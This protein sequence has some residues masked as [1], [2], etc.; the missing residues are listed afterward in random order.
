MSVL[1]WENIRKPSPEFLKLF[2]KTGYASESTLE[3][4]GI[5]KPLTPVLW[6]HPKIQTQRPKKRFMVDKYISKNPAEQS[7]CPSAEQTP[8]RCC[9][10]AAMLRTTSRG[11]GGKWKLLTQDGGNQ[12]VVQGSCSGRAWFPMGY[13][14]ALYVPHLNS[15]RI[16]SSPLPLCPCKILMFPQLL[17]NLSPHHSI[18]SLPTVFTR[19]CY[20]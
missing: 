17:M 14:A 16:P 18:F 1:S 2:L 4:A 5:T 13:E 20:V 8:E 10:S 19:L 6:L 12:A 7:H 3:T 11:S 9:H 15:Y